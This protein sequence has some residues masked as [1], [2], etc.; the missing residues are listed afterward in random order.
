MWEWS[1]NIISVFPRECVLFH[2]KWKQK[3]RKCWNK[4]ILCKLLRMEE[5]SRP[6]HRHTETEASHPVS[7]SV[8]VSLS[9]AAGV[10]G[11]L[12]VRRQRARQG[13]DG[14][15]FTSSGSCSFSLPGSSLVRALMHKSWSLARSLFLP[16]FTS[17]QPPSICLHL[18]SSPSWDRHETRSVRRLKDRLLSSAPLT[19]LYLLS[20]QFQ[21][22]FK[23][24]N[25]LDYVNKHTKQW[26]EK[27]IYN[28]T[29]T[30]NT[31]IILK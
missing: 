13:R 4:S 9:L 24:L 25:W 1:R 12:R 18:T 16:S 19:S 5:C 20:I 2:F 29:I 10:G 30:N 26:Q 27:D 14:R 31:K 15:T 7:R 3:W 21:F 6:P 8:S 22:N 23:V 28:N 11:S 17:Q